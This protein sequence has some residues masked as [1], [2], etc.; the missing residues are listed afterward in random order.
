M[1]VNDYSLTTI[2]SLNAKWNC[3][4]ESRDTISANM[5]SPQPSI[6]VLFLKQA[7]KKGRRKAN[8]IILC[9]V[10]KKLQLI[11]QRDQ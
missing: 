10:H 7:N 11:L 8:N 1:W 3:E 4:N 9:L 5:S 6:F 2:N